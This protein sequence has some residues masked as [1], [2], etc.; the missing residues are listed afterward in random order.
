MCRRSDQHRPSA[1]TDQFAAYASKHQSGD[2]A[3]PLTGGGDH[4][5][6]DLFGS[7]EKLIPWISF[8]LHESDLDRL[9]DF[10]LASQTL[11]RMFDAF[12][13]NHCGA[14]VTVFDNRCG[15][16]NMHDGNGASRVDEVC[17]EMRGF[18]AGVAE[19]SRDHNQARK[20]PRFRPDSEY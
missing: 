16:R 12:A 17:R 18:P 14:L 1:I 6:I 3:V 9:A 8:A 7:G 15:Q 2:Q 20:L 10:D 4:V 19:V 5:G 11:E 13:L